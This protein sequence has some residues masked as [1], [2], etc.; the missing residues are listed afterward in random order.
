MDIASHLEK[1]KRFEHARILLDPE[2]EFE[3]WYWMALSG[4][5]SAINAALH[6]A[7]LTDDGD[8]FTTQS[9]DV[10]MQGGTHDK[11]ASWTPKFM[12]DVDVIHIHLPE[13]SKPLTPALK[14]AYAA[15]QVLEDVR[16]PCVR[17]DKKITKKIIR[18]VD[19]A[20]KTTVTLCQGVIDEATSKA[21]PP[22]R[23]SR[24]KRA[25]KGAAAKFATS[26]TNKQRQL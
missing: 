21:T 12:W 22:I 26:K 14:Q 1:L 17:G 9:V 18:E 11:P 23:A 5:T 15:M 8:Y 7:Q 20:Y 19:A 2:T 16:D 3:M 10:Y 24:A 6:A 13:I 4:G 25:G